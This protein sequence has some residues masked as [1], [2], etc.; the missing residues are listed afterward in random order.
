MA[1]KSG[2]VAVALLVLSIPSARACDDFDEE[3]AVQ[4]AQQVAKPAQTAEAQQLPATPTAAPSPG[5]PD[6]KSFAAVEPRPAP[7]GTA[8]VVAGAVAR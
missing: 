3:L 1:M 4:A 6:V 7:S 2:L 5:Q 8:P